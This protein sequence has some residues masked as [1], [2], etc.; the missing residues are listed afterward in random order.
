ML[1]ILRRNQTI[2]IAAGAGIALGILNHF[3]YLITFLKLVIAVLLTG[4]IF[5]RPEAGLFVVAAFTP[6]MP[7]QYS[8]V[9]AAMTFASLLI[10]AL[11]NKEPIFE[12]S[13]LNVVAVL[14]AGNVVYGI[15]ISFNRGE[16]IYASL[17]YLAF[18]VFFFIVQKIIRNENYLYITI[19]L[20]VTAGFAVSIIGIFQYLT[21][22]D[23]TALWI[24]QNLFGGI[25][26]RVYG[27]LDNPN[28]LG[29]YLQILIP[30]AIF[31][32][33][34]KKDWLSRV[35][36]GLAAVSMF[37]SLLFTYSRSAWMGTVLSLVIFALLCPKQL[38]PYALGGIAFM[39]LVLNFIPSV[40]QRLKGVG[41]LLDTSTRY[42]IAVWMG[43]IGII[44]DFWACGIGMGFDN[45]SRFLSYYVP[46]DVIAIHSHNT[47]LQ[48]TVETGIMGLLLFLF[49]LILYI[50]QCL[51]TYL[52]SKTPFVK[53]LSAA[54]LSSMAG[55][56]LICIFDN[57][58]YDHCLKLVFWTM[59]GLGTAVSKLKTV[60]TGG[61]S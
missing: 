7:T 18:V 10:R 13:L 55:Y 33:I 2:L 9:L 51:S 19:A 29:N 3:L 24:D 56:L 21:G 15:I 30:L 60:E 25:E 12:F 52:T 40:I 27:T 49:L 61:E 44:K 11:V 41:T 4:L 5:L 57:T 39:P 28:V 35:Y 48:V 47:F 54:L 20:M 32:I 53:T 42:R 1:Q 37:A 16:S 58:L 22:L 34:I 14:F 23:T 36:F 59:L 38:I 43:S 45:F 31:L 46:S 50:R 8:M 17:I 6:V 26:T